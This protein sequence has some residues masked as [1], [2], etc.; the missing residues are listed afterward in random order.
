MRRG[1]KTSM[2]TPDWMRGSEACLLPLPEPFTAVTQSASRTSTETLPVKEITKI[3]IAAVFLWNYIC[4]IIAGETMIWASFPWQTLHLGD[5]RCFSFLPDNET[6]SDAAV[7]RTNSGHCDCISPE[8][9]RLLIRWSENKIIDSR[10]QG[11]GDTDG[12]YCNWNVCRGQGS[13]LQPPG[14]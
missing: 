4:S 13:K 7:K 1:K 9:T 8:D 2:T 6:A 14:H 12:G 5:W 10:S 3:L 11:H